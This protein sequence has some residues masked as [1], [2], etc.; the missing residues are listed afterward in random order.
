[1]IGK[2]ARTGKVRFRS[3]RTGDGSSRSPWM[4][5]AQFP[6]LGVLPRYI[7]RMIKMQQQSFAP[8]KKSEPDEIVIDERRQ[9]SHHDRV[10][11]EC[12][13]LCSLDLVPNCGVAVH[14]LQVVIQ[15]GIGVVNHRVAEMPDS[16]LGD[17]FE[18]DTIVRIA[19]CDESH[20]APEETQFRIR[21][22]T[23]MLQA[24]SHEQVEPR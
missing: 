12:L 9:R 20:S 14:V 4:L 22:E 7:A 11:V 15:R 8:I 23:S 19:P 16:F 24:P 17:T 3:E 2:P 21:P 6:C 13:R 18:F 1:M 10:K 5:A